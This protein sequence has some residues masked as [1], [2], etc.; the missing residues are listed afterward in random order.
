MLVRRGVRLHPV[1]DRLDALDRPARC[2]RGR[3]R[4]RVVGADRR[5]AGE[6]NPDVVRPGDLRHRRKIILDVLVGHRTGVARDVIGACENDNNSRLQRDD[7]GAEPDEHLGRRLRADAA[8]HVV[9]AGEKS[10][11]SRLLPEIGDRIADEHGVGASNGRI[12]VAI[13][14]KIRPIA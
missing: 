4:R 6:H 13:A 14:G 5:D 9:L 12:R 3:I 11:E 10:A 2:L 8:V 1:V 7:V